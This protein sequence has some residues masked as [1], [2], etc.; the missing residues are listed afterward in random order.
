MSVHKIGKAKINLT[1]ERWEVVGSRKDKFKVNPRLVHVR[2]EV[3]GIKADYARKL[4]AIKPAFSRSKRH[5]EFISE[6][7]KYEQGLRECLAK[8][9]QEILEDSFSLLILMQKDRDYDHPRGWRYGLYRGVIY[10]FDR[11]GYSDEEMITQ[12][13][14]YESR[15]S[16]SA[17]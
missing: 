15:R 6:R 11:S 12:I 13:S 3:K 4:K 17:A 10:Q 2:S 1:T 7:R 8:I 16:V 14:A 9:Y 5:A